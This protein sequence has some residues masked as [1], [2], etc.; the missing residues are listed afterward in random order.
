MSGR[1]RA[2]SSPPPRELPGWE[3]VNDTHG[4]VQWLC[5]LQD[6]WAALQ[7]EIPHAVILAWR[8]GHANH[9]AGASP[10]PDCWCEGCRMVLPNCTLDGF[11]T[12]ISPCQVCG[13]EPIAWADLSIP[14]GTF[15]PWKT[16]RGR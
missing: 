8:N 15:L 13:S 7:E 4:F 2:G 16:Q 10:V 14:W 12:H 1:I 6:G 3:L 5:A 9:P 11:G